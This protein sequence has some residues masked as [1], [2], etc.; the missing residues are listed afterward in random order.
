MSLKYT[1][2]FLWAIYLSY[3][4]IL[5]SCEVVWVNRDV[6]D[7]F[8]V[9]KDGCTYDSS[10]CTNSHATCINRGGECLCKVSNANFKN[11]T[12]RRGDNKGYG[13][14]DDSNIRVGLVGEF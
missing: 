12:T 13:C 14:L 6:V 3:K 10:V 1:V 8:H 4:M 2:V 9:G 5:T 7:S 11:P